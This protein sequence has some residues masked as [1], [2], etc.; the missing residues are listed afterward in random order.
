MRHA[1]P[2]CEST[3]R[4]TSFLQYHLPDNES[5]LQC[6]DSYTR[7]FITLSFSSMNATWWGMC[8]VTRRSRFR[9]VSGPSTECTP[10]RSKSS[11]LQDLR[12]HNICVRI[13][14][15]TFNSSSSDRFKQNSARRNRS[16]SAAKSVGRFSASTRFIRSAYRI[17]AS[18]R[19]QTTSRIDHLPST[20]RASASAPA[21]AC[22]ASRSTFTPLEYASM[23]LATSEG[24]FCTLE[25]FEFR[26]ESSATLLP[27]PDAALP[28]DARAIC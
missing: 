24:L 27:L 20:G 9:S 10:T 22:T 5:G 12:M 2:G 18:A 25:P 1:V 13:A 14:A 19:W 17:S 15:T 21:D 4:M 6:A 28:R 16:G 7:P 3:E 23:S 11:A 8:A 26:L